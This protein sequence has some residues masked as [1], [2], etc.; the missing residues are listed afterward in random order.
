MTTTAASPTE[1]NLHV[2]TLAHKA[3]LVKLTSSKP[4]TAR[5]ERDAEA[6]V[7]DAEGDTS[8]RVSSHIFASPTNPV[9]VLL[10]LWGGIY[11]YHVAHTIEYQKRGARL[12]PMAQYETYTQTMKKLIADVESATSA[13]MPNYPGLVLKDIDDRTAMA[14]AKGRSPKAGMETDYPSAEEFQ[15]KL[16]SRFLFSPVPDVS[17]IM[18]DMDQD[19]KDALVQQVQDAEAN[20]KRSVIAGLHDPLAKLIAKLQVGIKAEGSIFR[21]SM[22]EN[23]VAQCELAKSLAMGDETILAMVSEL[24]AAIKPHAVYIDGL[25]ESPI[26]RADAA[27]KLQAVA[28]RMSFMSGN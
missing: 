10:N 9:R 23:V 4:T 13:L 18:F 7:Q 24:R 15:S 6:R 19:D 1:L 5:R 27:A 20:G 8:L 28:N 25:R 17:H 14:L 2:K 12:L 26:T 21:D 11:T 22:V 3:I 16:Y